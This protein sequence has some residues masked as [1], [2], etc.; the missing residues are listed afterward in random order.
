MKVVR[1]VWLRF[2]ES[3]KKSV[4]FFECFCLLLMHF[5]WSFSVNACESIG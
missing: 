4:C 5:T 3:W 2:F 1:G